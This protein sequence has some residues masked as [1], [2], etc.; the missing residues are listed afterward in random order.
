METNNQNQE[1]YVQV[2]EIDESSR[3]TALEDCDR[4]EKGD[5]VALICDEYGHWGW[6]RVK[7]NSSKSE[8]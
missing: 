4:W 2:I 1:E 5:E 7:D 8:K 3:Q 6:D